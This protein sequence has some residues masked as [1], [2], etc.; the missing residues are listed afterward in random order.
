MFNGFKIGKLKLKNNLIAA[1]MAGFSSLPFRLLVI[2]QGCSLVISEMVAS[3]GAIKSPDRTEHLFKN[4]KSVRPYG[5]QVWGAKPKYIYEAIQMLDDEGVDLFDINM[6]CPARKICKKD[7]GSALMKNP[8]LA[9]EVIRSARSATKKPL[10]V[11]M[12]SGWDENSINCVEIACI[13]ENEGADAVIVHPRTRTQE[14]RGKSD[15]SKISEVKKS[16]KIPVIGNGDIKNRADAIKMI[17]QTNCDGI[18][19]G[20]AA[21]GNPWIFAE[22]LNENYIKPTK[23]ELGK[24]A[25]RHLNLLK[26][27]MGERKAVLQMRKMLSMY[28][29]GQ[30]GIKSF[31]K[32]VYTI[33]D[34]QILQH[35]IE[36][37]FGVLPFCSR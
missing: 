20:R 24:V 35:K 16:V 12:R 21:V 9:G 7:A 5:I 8:V 30:K 37:F 10:T 4:D 15:W 1:P 22:I 27:L 36:Q 6:G 11:K 13:A 31:M 34:S 26:S 19:I 32:N 28:G 3:V 25:I 33:K 23:D 18:M 2:E 14:F 29:K 17:N